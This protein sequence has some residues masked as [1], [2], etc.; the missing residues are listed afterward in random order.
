MVTAA[1]KLKKKKTKHLFLGRKPMINPDSI[2]K[3][4]DI[5]LPKI[6]I[7]KGI[8]FPVVLY[9][10]EHVRVGL[11][12]LLPLLFN[13]VLE[14]LATAIRAE[15]EIQGI[16]IGKVKLSLFAGNVI[17][18]I[19]NHKDSTRKFLELISEYSKLQDI[20]STCRNPLH[21]YTLIMRK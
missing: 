7:V 6:C 19:E 14:V 5:T 9:G 1:M 11:Y 13:M 15:K 16:Q 17:L 10:C 18:Y 2:L 20:K 4:R 12:P 8:V 3:N 21:S